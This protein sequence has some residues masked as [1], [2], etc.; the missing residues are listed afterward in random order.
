MGIVS[1]LDTIFSAVLVGALERKQTEEFI[2]QKREVHRI[3]ITKI[4]SEFPVNIFQD[5]Y[6][7]F[8]ELIKIG[9]KIF[10]PDTLVDV[11]ERNKDLVLDSPY[12]DMTQWSMSNDGKQATEDE[13]LLA[14]TEN[15]KEKLTELSNIAVT[16]DEFTSACTNFKDYYI[17]Q[18]KMETAQNMTIILG[19]TGLYVKSPGKRR[20]LYQG[21]EDSDLYYTER[22]NILDSLSH[23]ETIQ[24]EKIDSDW[25]VEEN[26]RDNTPDEEGILDTGLYEID[27]VIG[28]FRRSHIITIL[29]PTKG[30]KTRFSNYLVDRAL[31]A[32][33]NVCV[34]PQEGTKE[35]WTANQ[36]A[37][38]CY[39]KH[40]IKYDS[41]KILNRDF[42][43]DEAMKRYVAGARTEL[44][45]GIK[46]GR[47]SFMKGTAY[48]ETFI[49]E[50]ENHYR[51]TN[52]FD[53]LVIDPLINI[54][55]LR[56][57]T[58]VDRISQAYVDIKDYIANKMEKKALAIIPAQLKQE[59]ID[60]LRRNPGETI[61]IT[62][63]GE[64]SETIRS[65]DEV[66][67]L[68]SS[69]EERSANQMKIYSVASRHSG[70]FNDFTA[71]C[72]LGCCHFEDRTDLK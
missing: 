30:G 66:I 37:C 39:R 70:N 34:W 44:A 69:K 10:S 54:Q 38:I 57:K 13:K 28:Q 14:F 43:G 65:A 6:A 53:V 27:R 32:G 55:S 41:K 26:K 63:G 60:Y 19:D 50:L 17:K 52:Q 21:V 61:D 20:R 67:G 35:E 56:G 25:L 36:I 3:C 5:E 16:L 51:K 33:L 31:E 23:K 40:K 18:F 29:G 42:G 58:K 49:S 7:L 24:S 48:V 59:T 12:I 8:Y 4:I 2:R 9:Y 15:A 71:G 64:S 11:I 62:A 47:L 45:L 1:S 46:R 72:Y 68:F 22:Q